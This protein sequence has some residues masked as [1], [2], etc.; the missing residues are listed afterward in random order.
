MADINYQT[1]QIFDEKSAQQKIAD[2]EYYAAFQSLIERDPIAKEY[3][4]PDDIVYPFGKETTP[5]TMRGSL[6]GQYIPPKSTYDEYY[7][8]AKERKFPLDPHTRTKEKL[9]KG[10]G[11]IFIYQQPLSTLT[12][13]A[14]VKYGVD[15]FTKIRTILHEA[16]HKAFDLNEEYKNFIKNNRLDEEVFNR[17][18][19]MEI[20]PEIKDWEI[21]SI[22]RGYEIGYKGLK[23]KYEK[24]TKEFLK[25]FKKKSSIKD[26][27]F[28]LFN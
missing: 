25:R 10:E 28:N 14:P 6:S 24:S 22:D 12:Q 21:K 4:D 1:D 15:V 17:F 27:I 18:L 26:Q 2:D 13:K 3:F 16:R 8:Y 11:T 7:S 5:D 20:F 9:D 23:K 19:D